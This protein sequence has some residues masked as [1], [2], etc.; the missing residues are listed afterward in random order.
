M[1]F[2]EASFKPTPTEAD[3]G[4]LGEQV[5]FLRA[6]STR[7]IGQGSDVS[8]K[9]YG[10]AT[11]FSE[12][13]ADP[14]TREG[15]KFER[16]S[17]DAMG[18]AVWG[19]DVTDR[20]AVAVSTYIR[21]VEDL[22]DDW[23]AAV[24]SDFGVTLEG[25]VAKGSITGGMPADVQSR[26]L[27][28]EIQ[29]K[30]EAK[31]AQVEGDYA[32]VRAAYEQAAEDTGRWLKG[33]PTPA[34]LRE[35]GNGGAAGWALYNIFGADA[36]M[37][38][39]AQDGKALAEKIAAMLKNGDELTPELRE[40]LNLMLALAARAQ[41]MQGL[42]D[43]QLAPGELGFLEA[44]FKGM[45]VRDITGGPD[46][47]LL[48]NVAD[49]LKDLDFSDAD[50]AL[51]LGA[52]GGGLMTLSNSDFGGGMGRLPAS[53]RR[54]LEYLTF[55]NNDKRFNY[56]DYT[57]YLEGLA[58]MLG[59]VRGA[60]DIDGKQI[61]G[62]LQAGREL[63]TGLMWMIADTFD[64]ENDPVLNHLNDLKNPDSVV[65][66]IMDIVT[67][68]RNLNAQLLSGVIQHPDY[69]DDSTEHLLRGMFGHQWED[70]G[71]SVSKLIDWI[72]AA[73]RDI[74]PALQRDAAEAYFGLLDTM[75]N[76][77]VGGHWKD[78][79]YTFFTDGFGEINGF[80]N[81]PLGVAN[82]VISKSLA[83]ATVPYL[84]W[85]ADP[86]AEHLVGGEKVEFPTDLRW[87]IDPAD[88]GGYITMQD[89]ANMFEL[90]MGSKSGAQ[91]LGQAVYAKVY[92]DGSNLPEWSDG[93]GHADLG[94]LVTDG[95]GAEAYANRTGRLLGFLDSGYNNVLA[96]GTDDAKLSAAENK[97][98]AAWMRAGSAIAKEVITSIPPV[99][100]AKI[101]WEL[102][103]KQSLEMGKYGPNVAETDGWAF[104]GPDA[105][106]KGDDGVSLEDMKLKFGHNV[107]ETLVQDPNSG[108][109]VAELRELAPELTKKDADG[110]WVM[111]PADE[112][113]IGNDPMK[114]K[115]EQYT[116]DNALRDYRSFLGPHNTARYNE[117]MSTLDDQRED[118]GENHSR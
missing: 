85:F 103:A 76:E 109:T 42:E 92:L 36:A 49:H 39:D 41:S 100:G 114:P 62:R 68:D 63:S 91:S 47:Y 29:A 7:I 2:T 17:M 83:D 19:A 12:L 52:M 35:L 104:Q 66:D 26:I 23:N 5:G 108:R 38:L 37:P 48:Y 112:V 60:E 21:D 1:A 78:S 16:A 95:D 22:Q 84:D 18:G 72:P 80:K 15:G 56:N 40:Q 90:A 99:R 101:G 13:V 6:H 61:F 28:N 105:P 46:N 25:L 96:D 106:K 113:L 32:P 27:D 3:P 107:V 8:E 86:N 43:T 118:Y 82:P 73:S 79:A 53:L 55:G 65:G 110:N 58:P 88:R 57:M 115:D 111:R 75:T 34:N 74:D 9:M 59:S 30:G 4:K 71:K 20:W 94:K 98:Q 116:A 51:V 70:D 102:L 93:D 50:Q 87:S 11:Q 24:R 81:A 14:I 54:P 89:R 97:S 64:H 117:Y 67:R 77:E 33:G 31:L 44:F 45:D 10:T 69:G